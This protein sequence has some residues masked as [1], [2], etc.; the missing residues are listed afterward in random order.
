[1]LLDTHAL[2]WWLDGDDALPADIDAVIRQPSTDVF[3]S[4]ISLAEISVKRSI[5]KL[6][7][8]W[9]PDE[10]L[11]DNGLAVLDF[12]SDHAR[13]MLDLPLHHRDPFDRMLIAQ[14]LA[15]DLVFATVDPRC[16]AYGIRT[17]PAA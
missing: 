17:L 3:V 5:G 13:R 11:H 16:R 1:M 9:I 10:L 4:T 7:A 6:R 12:T 14:A 8:P 15:D 2:I